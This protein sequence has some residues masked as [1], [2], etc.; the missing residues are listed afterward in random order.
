MRKSDRRLTGRRTL[1]IVWCL[2]ALVLWFNAR[3]SAA[4]P[5][6]LDPNPVHW[7]VYEK[8]WVPGIAPALADEPIR[9]EWDASLATTFLDDVSTKWVR[10]NHCGTCHTSVPYLM[11]MELDAN[12][13]HAAAVAEV[14]EAVIRNAT[15][16]LDQ[17]DQFT[18]F[19]VP[20]AASALAIQ[21]ARSG[22]PADPRVVRLF[23]SMW[24]LQSSDGSWLYPKQDG[25]LPF[26]ER[27]RTYVAMLVALAAGY[28][29]AEVAGSHLS[30]PALKRL[31]HYLQV[32]KPYSVHHQAVLL[33]ASV[34]TSGLLTSSEQS[35][36]QNRLLALQRPDG[37]WTLPSLG[38]WTRHD[39]SFNDPTGP[40]DGY[41]TGLA[42]VVLCERGLAQSPAVA[43]ALAWLERNQRVSGRWYTRSLYSDRFK[44]YLSN[45][46]TAYAVMALTE[47]RR[48]T[49]SP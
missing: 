31:R 39:G 26:L 1:P 43:R 48:S 45:A 32:H 46:A 33:W 9:G 49:P 23:E 25:F 13:A 5:P 30:S 21:D 8:L 3:D 2:G 19:L 35:L 15:S 16:H 11:T 4:S 37:G 14:R 24:Q 18:N 36:Y 12:G 42:A 20:P 47:C 34:R 38:S 41:A 40:S 10:H 44:G 7:D 17:P 29:P 27:D 22:A 6:S 28:D